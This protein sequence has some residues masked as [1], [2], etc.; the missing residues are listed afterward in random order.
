MNDA[1]WLRRLTLFLM[2]TDRLTPMHIRLYFQFFTMLFCP[3]GLLTA[4]SPSENSTSGL[5]ETSA[6]SRPLELDV[7]SFNIR[8]GLA[9]DGENQWDKRKDR[10]R[11]LESDTFWLS[12]T[13]KNPRPPGDTTTAASAPG[14]D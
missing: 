6:S 13:P 12:E 1:A 3:V 8:N 10:F 14:R 7:M 9:K 5:V 2:T 4:A 11:L